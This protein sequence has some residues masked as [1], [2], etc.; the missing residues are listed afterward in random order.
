MKLSN[1]AL[2]FILWVGTAL[3]CCC[4]LI[5]SVVFYIPVSV[6]R[7]ISIL[8]LAA[9]GFFVFKNRKG[10]ASYAIVIA[11]SFLA[12]GIFITLAYVVML[13]AILVKKEHLAR[14]FWY[15]PLIIQIVMEA[16]NNIRVFPYLSIF[17]IILSI[18][19]CIGCLAANFAISRW[20]A[21]SLSENVD[22]AYNNPNNNNPKLAYYAEL[23]AHGV[24]SDEE[25]ETKKTE[26]DKTDKYSVS[27]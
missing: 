15:A 10:A 21:N 23:H 2:A 19:A 8:F 3:I 11:L 13:L 14:R 18:A 9:A 22:G 7:I 24:L 4:I 5:Q 17:P 6:L 20:L 12:F 16:I 1:K 27:R 26:L 25:F